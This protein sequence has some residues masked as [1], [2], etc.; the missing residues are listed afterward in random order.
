[1]RHVVMAVL[2]VLGHSA[3]VSAEEAVGNNPPAAVSKV[4]AVVNALGPGFDEVYSVRDGEFKEAVSASL[5]N[6]T[7]HDLLL[8]SLRLGYGHQDSLIY[9]SVRLDLPGLSKRFVPATVRGVATTGYLNALWAAVG[10]YGSVG[11]FAGYSFDEDAA[12]YGVALGGQVS[13]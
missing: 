10:K 13:F 9:S 7:S 2:F 6:F 4:Q 11:P 12:D 1:M 8:A 3:V 5:W